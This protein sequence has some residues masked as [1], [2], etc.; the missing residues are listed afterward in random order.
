MRLLFVGGYDIAGGAIAS[1]MYRE[2]AQIAW[3]TND[4]DARLW[5]EKIHGRVFRQK[6]SRGSC[7]QIL[8]GGAVDCAVLLTA[9]W[10]ELASGGASRGSLLEMLD[11]VLEEA[12]ATGTRRVCLLSSE[13]LVEEEPLDAGLEELRAAERLAE[14]FCRQHD[15]RLL[16][17]RMGF[18]FDKDASL[19][20]E[21]LA[22]RLA[23]E[24]AAGAQA[25]CPFAPDSRLD[26]LSASDV[27]DAFLR[28]YN[29][30]AD[31]VHTVLSGTSV[32][33]RE[34][35]ATAAR[36]AG[37]A[38]NVSY[39]ILDYACD[40][41][42]AE[43]ARL[44]CGWM[45]FHLFAETGEEYLREGLGREAPSPEPTLR[46]RWRQLAQSHPLVWETIQNLVL[47]VVACLL[48]A[49]A[50][51]WSDL[52]YVDVRL[53]YV[54]IIAICFGMRQGLLATGLACASYA[55]SL[56]RSGIDVSYLGYSVSTWIPF[57]VYG[58]AGAFGGYWSDK[59]NDEYETLSRE[60][61]EQGQRYDLLKDLYREVVALKNRL[62]KQIVT[63][64]DS[65]NQFYSIASELES[66]DPRMLLAR[67]VSAIE[68]AMESKG[69]AIYLLSGEG[70]RWARLA[71]CS[72]AWSGAL[73]P[74]LDLQS[75]PALYG[76]IM[77]GRVFVNV[78][79]DARSPS[80]A[81]P[82]MQDGEPLAVVAV[83][84]MPMEHFTQDFENRFQ[85]MVKMVRDSLLRA[86]AH[87][88]ENQEQFFLPHTQIYRPDAFSRELE[89]LKKIDETYGCPYSV[90]RVRRARRVQSP[91]ALYRQ[92]GPLLRATDFMG[93]GADDEVRAVF[94]YVDGPRRQQIKE[95]L[96]SGGL[97]VEWED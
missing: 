13:M 7:G 57:I 51:D 60:F 20:R 97:V 19:P 76:R 94:L 6:I 91:W 41:S 1:R 18:L 31:G 26:L 84:G 25:H 16:V 50:E 53:L 52:R 39:G 74:S 73:S 46:A 81:M 62:Q 8:D 67:A 93:V 29:L 48:A 75:I 92:A 37:A 88:Q 10:R 44:L 22:G 54:I 30:E 12:V 61:A 56:L 9:P 14:A 3:L 69:V 34:L 49:L 66:D 24:M 68:Q 83:Y 77:H 15:V 21:S 45:P 55:T 79:L 64:R 85:T 36:A 40:E 63:S 28:L 11:A 23:A 59:K 89:T 82:I 87:R 72:A 38:E 33:A 70:R 47:F 43:A 58:V 65:I 35:C 71:V 42:R 5:G 17:L 86:F 32:T 80:I 2:G 27:A 96:E 95:R 4:S 90:A 78:A